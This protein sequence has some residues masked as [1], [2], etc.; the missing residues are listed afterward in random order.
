MPAGE[1]LPKIDRS[2][3]PRHVAVIMDG[4]GRW[5]KSRGRPRLAGHRAGA[6]SV[7]EAVRVSAELG[8]E[9]LT[10][11]AFSTENWSRPKAEVEGLMILLRHTLRREA[12]ELDKSGVRLRVSGRV[13]ELP[14]AV[15]K[16]LARAQD[17]LAD[18]TGL[19]LNLALNYGGRQDVV[20]A[21][22]DLIGKGAAAVTEEDISAHLST[23]GLPDPDLLIRTSGESRLSNFLLWQSAYAEFHVTPVLWPD[24]RRPQLYHALADYQSRH[25]RFGGLG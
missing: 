23:A 21:V 8:I 2:R 24:F 6:E 1:P 25:R 9:V 17:L 13:E 18:N 19:I 4:N 20:D 5:A 11:Y 22:N 15:R 3:L 14:A 12:A 10:L 7:R 16:E